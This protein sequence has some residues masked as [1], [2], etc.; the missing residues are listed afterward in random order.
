[1]QYAVFTS[2]ALLLLVVYVPFL[3]GVFDTVALD[4]V[5][6]AYVLPLT[7]L[8]AIVEELTKA[9]LRHADQ[10]KATPLQTTADLRG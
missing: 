4:A 2:F 5:H 3:Q 7:I 9:Y 1:M 10:Q 8:P 6:W